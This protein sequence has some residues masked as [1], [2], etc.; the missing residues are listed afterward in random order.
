[1]KA[2]ATVFGCA[3]GICLVGPSGWGKITL[4]NLIA[5]IDQDFDGQVTLNGHIGGRLAYVFQTP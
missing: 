4:L 2:N 5:G 3:I 1:M